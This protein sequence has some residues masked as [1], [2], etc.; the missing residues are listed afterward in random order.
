[1]SRYQPV[2]ARHRTGGGVSHYAVILT[3]I[4]V[5]MIAFG[6]FNIFI[7]SVY[8]YLFNDVVPHAFLARFMALFRVVG[9]G[10][11]RFTAFLSSN[12]RSRTCT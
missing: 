10:G 5:F 9:S 11:A 6:F 12:T 2:V 3:V 4:S 8:Y 7:S 1:M